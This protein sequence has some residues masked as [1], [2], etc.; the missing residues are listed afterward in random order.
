M[1]AAII[2]LKDAQFGG[3]AEAVFHATHNTVA[4]VA[5]AFKLD[6][7]IDDVFQDFR[8]SQG[9]V[10]GN[11]TDKEDGDG[12]SLAKCWNSAAHSLICEMEPAAESSRLLCSV[13]I[14]STITMSGFKTSICMKISCVTVSVKIKQC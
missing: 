3:G 14:E 4:V 11:V 6:D 8:T 9:A 2:H 7:C 10:F 1:K 13:W 12:R 5:V